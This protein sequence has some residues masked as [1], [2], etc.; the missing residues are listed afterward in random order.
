MDPYDARGRFRDARVKLR[1]AP[2]SEPF[3]A[4]PWGK[5]PSIRSAQR[6]FGAWWTKFV[7]LYRVQRSKRIHKIHEDPVF[8]ELKSGSFPTPTKLE[9]ALTGMEP[10]SYR[11][12]AN[13]YIELNHMAV[14]TRLER[15]CELPVC[16]RPTPR[17]TRTDWHRRAVQH[18]ALVLYGIRSAAGQGGCMRVVAQGSGLWRRGTLASCTEPATGCRL[19]RRRAR[20][21][22]ARPRIRGSRCASSA[23]PVDG[24]VPA[25]KGRK[26]AAKPKAPKAKVGQK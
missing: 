26:R 12:D 24:V 23:Q 10:G 7:P 8:S 22:C 15:V 19:I 1:G 17:S 6:S 14:G 4:A 9:L 13:A 2:V 16:G 11:M 18:R 5:R 3:R 25:T 20:G 21:G